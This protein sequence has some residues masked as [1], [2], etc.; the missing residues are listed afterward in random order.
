MEMQ[1]NK[2]PSYQNLFSDLGKT[3]YGEKFNIFVAKNIA[4]FDEQYQVYAD[5]FKENNFAQTQRISEYLA[6]V[7]SHVNFMQTGNPDPV[8]LHNK[9]LEYN[10]IINEYKEEEEIVKSFQ[11]KLESFMDK[12]VDINIVTIREK[13]IP[14]E[15]SGNLRFG[16]KNF[17]E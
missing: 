5:W 4:L 9:Q 8:T 17:L 16:I 13:D 12:D 10:S 14:K 11:A 7:K 15:L 2:I 1:R 3:N 6:L